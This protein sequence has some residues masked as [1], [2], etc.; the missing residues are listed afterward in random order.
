MLTEAGYN[1]HNV[2]CK[3]MSQGCYHTDISIWHS[4]PLTPYTPTTMTPTK[5]NTQASAVENIKNRNFI[6]GS[7]SADG[8]LSVSANPA[9]HG[10]T[11]LARAEAKRLARIEPG[12]MFVILQLMGAEL[13]PTNTVSI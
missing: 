6:V 3:A 13:V 5:I 11:T 7:V 8:H 9:T 1:V 10:T 12:K 4:E 2:T